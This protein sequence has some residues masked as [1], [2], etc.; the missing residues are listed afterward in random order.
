MEYK[1]IKIVRGYEYLIE[2]L[3]PDLSKDGYSYKRRKV[4]EGLRKANGVD[5]RY[6]SIHELLYLHSEITLEKIKYLQLTEQIRLC[7]IDESE[8][9]V[10]SS[11]LPWGLRLDAKTPYKLTEPPLIA[12]IIG[13]ADTIDPEIHYIN[14]DDLHL[15]GIDKAVDMPV[16]EAALSTGADAVPVDKLLVV[17]FLSPM[18]K[19]LI[20]LW[21]AIREAKGQKEAKQAADD[22]FK[23]H[24]ELQIEKDD[25]PLDFFNDRKVD[26]SKIRIMGNIVQAILRKNTYPFMCKNK[27]MKFLKI[28]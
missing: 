8:L 6:I 19:D 27:I 24:P 7:V 14:E 2:K 21:T 25:L 23:N 22:Y 28:K 10:I 5:G 4:L 9:L 26:K 17:D 3:N 13:R 15:L 18:K 12:Y 16:V 20:D 1:D 11:N